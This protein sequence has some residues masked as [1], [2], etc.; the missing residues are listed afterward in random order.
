MK[1]REF[2]AF[3]SGAT[4]WPLVAR[5]QQRAMPVIGF[6]NSRSESTVEPLLKVF[7]KG[8]EETGYVEHRNVDIEYRWAD[9]D[10]RRLPD[11]A[12]DLV[13]RNVAVIAATGGL[14]SAQAAKAAT[15]SIP[16]LFIAGFDP[17]KEGLA[18]SMGRP[19]GNAT[20]VSVYTTELASKRLDLLK[21]VLP[22]LSKLGVLSNPRSISAEIEKSD[23]EKAAPNVKV[24]LLFVDASTGDELGKA[25]SEVVQQG[26][27]ALIVSAD[28]F[29]TDQLEKIVEL[30]AVY[31]LPA[32]YPWSQYAHAGGLMSYGPPLTWAYQ[33]I[34]TYAGK[35]LNGDK[36]SEMPIHLPRDFELVINGKTA[37]SLGLSL[38]PNV[39]SIADKVI[40]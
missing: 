9:G 34:G 21:K 37:K 7:L 1:R 19:G 15:S 25:F 8:L 4:V 17:V 32:S 40:D 28:P 14:V 29:F 38:S 35:I 20:G 23:L 24:Q 16:V 12:A 31:H 6:L 3:V 22:Q 10:Y 26:A 39:Q 5:A 36:P 18:K 13:R 30:A 11:L 33:Q 2:I 27:E